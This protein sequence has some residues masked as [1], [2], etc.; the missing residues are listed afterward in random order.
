LPRVALSLTIDRGC[1]H[2]DA[3]A[4][5]PMPQRNL[6]ILLLATA[7]SYACYV[8]GEQNPFAR[9]V[10]SGL[11]EIDAGSLERV[12]S[13]ELFE[14]AMEGM[15]DVLERHGDEHSRFFS[16]EEAGALRGEIRQ[17][18]GGIGVRLRY[19]GQ[20]PRLT[21][22]FPPEAGTP[23]AR[24]NLQA[25]DHI[26]AIDGT[27]TDKLD[28][29]GVLGLMRGEAGSQVRLTIQHANE[30]TSRTVDLVREI[31]ETESIFG[32]TRG[33]DGR[34][35]YLLPVDP[36]IAHVRIVMFGDRTA[37]ELIRVL[38]QTTKDGAEAVVLD[39]RDN[40]GGAFEAA[41]AV[42]DLL[43]PAERTIVE[44]RGRN[45]TLRRQYQSTGIGRYTRLP[46]AVVVNQES[47]SAAEIVA[48]CLQDH[49]RAA[50]VGQRTF[51]KGTVQQMLPLGN[52]S[53][54]KLTWAS[55]WRPSGI[56]LHR[57]A[58]APE[59][60]SWGVTPDAGL[61]LKLSPDDYNAYLKY[62]ELRDLGE[63]MNGSAAAADGNSSEDDKR[64]G[65]FVDRQ[66]MLAVD[67]LR[68]SLDGSS[69]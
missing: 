14:G 66:L 47:A 68:E 67:H 3:A 32:D 27:P 28:M 56:N 64:A 17:Q 5:V 49:R 60:G 36:R 55:F 62:R 54:L 51:G 50:V 39:L 9:H 59:D 18:F 40:S 22:V 48:A 16:D 12:P 24:A 53:L 29:D 43:L 44:T 45:G 57:M 7:V 69:L 41:V 20:P 52:D 26:L 6:V 46:T 23:A 34:W 61:E 13:R 10:A 19:M 37:E 35:K 1:F 63:I 38:D 21:V 65:N 2:V 58:D 31:I 8:R 4:R 11:S 30:D 15:V 25:G 33:R 42:C